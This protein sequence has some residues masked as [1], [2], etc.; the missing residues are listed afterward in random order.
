MQ[1]TVTESTYK[2]TCDEEVAESNQ[3]LRTIYYSSI[4]CQPR[5]EQVFLIPDAGIFI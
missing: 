4:K 2:N 5:A 1:F 3:A